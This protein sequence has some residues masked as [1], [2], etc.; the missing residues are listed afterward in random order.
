M[1]I[2]YSMFLAVDIGNS[3][4]VLALKSEGKW[5]NFCRISTVSSPEHIYTSIETWL[6]EIQRIH[7]VHGI[8]ISSVVPKHTTPIADQLQQQLGC[9]PLI[10]SHNLKLDIQL[11]YDNPA[12]LG[13]DRI[14]SSA[15][16][17]KK[18]GGSLIVIDFGTATTYNCI[19]SDGIFIGGAIAAGIET[20]VLSLYT[21]T[22]Q[23]PKVPLDLPQQV[24]NSNTIESIQAGV[25]YGAL[26]ATEQM[27]KRMK[28][29]MST[30]YKQQPLVVATGGLAWW[31]VQHTSVI[32]HHEPHLV[33]DGIE[34]I[35]MQ[36]ID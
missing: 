14:C 32:T 6:K 29:E 19:T 10:I 26:D 21:R 23:L 22:A 13:V 31:V 18:F 33:L 2:D 1:M 16:A 8:G 35:W 34:Q 27:I 25:L 7:S 28:N 24:I 11:C 12:T 3:D 4:I 15:A 9:T 20:S 17:F 5:S 36:N 30:V